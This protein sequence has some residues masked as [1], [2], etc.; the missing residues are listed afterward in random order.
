MDLRPGQ[1]VSLSKKEKKKYRYLT[2]FH[3]DVVIYDIDGHLKT[4]QDSTRVSLVIETDSVL[5]CCVL[6]ILASIA[7]FLPE[8]PVAAGGEGSW[9]DDNAAKENSDKD[10]RLPRALIFL[11]IRSILF[12]VSSYLSSQLGRILSCFA[13]PGWML[14]SSHW[15]TQNTDT[16]KLA[17]SLSI[18]KVLPAIFYPLMPWWDEFP[19]VSNF[20]PPPDTKL[21]EYRPELVIISIIFSLLFFIRHKHKVY[22]HTTPLPC[23]LK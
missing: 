22:T 23:G 4:Y 11:D 8:S 12:V 2:P 9:S 15:P 20:L 17:H 18:K 16:P 21:C 19:S 10:M 7:I 5:Y 14:R 1:W 3:L 13:P 6:G